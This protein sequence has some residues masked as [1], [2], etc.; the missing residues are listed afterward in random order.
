M[1]QGWP[2]PGSEN[3]NEFVRGCFRGAPRRSELNVVRPIGAFLVCSP[4]LPPRK[5]GVPLPM[6]GVM[7]IPASVLLTKFC[8]CS[9]DSDDEDAMLAAAEAARKAAKRSQAAGP[10]PSSQAAMFRELE[11]A[12]QRYNNSKEATAG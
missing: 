9:G 5:W 7:A 12:E 6:F 3:E 11:S 2:T 8:S 4:E 1:T 10:G